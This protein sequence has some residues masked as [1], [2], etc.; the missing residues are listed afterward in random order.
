MATVNIIRYKHK[1]NSNGTSPII[2]QIIHQRKIKRISLG[3]RYDCTSD[4]WN[5]AAKEYNRNFPE[6]KAKNVILQKFKT[7]AN[8]IIENF[9]KVG[10]PFSFKAFETIFRGS[11]KNVSTLFE[12]FEERINEMKAQ[13]QLSNASIYKATKSILNQFESNKNLAFTDI[14]YQ[15]L[16][17]FEIY[18]KERGSNGGGINNHMRT[19]RALINE[20]MKRGFLSLEQ[21]PFKSAWNGNGYSFSHI[22]SD[23]K[24]RAVSPED[25][26]KLKNFPIQ[27]F[28]DLNFAY[29]IFMFSYYS[30]GMNINDIFKL[31]KS[32]VYNNRLSFNRTK[33]GKQMSVNLTEPLKTILKEFEN[34]KNDFLFPVLNESHHTPEDVKKQIANTLKQINYRLKKIAEILEIDVDLTSYVARHNYATTLKRNGGDVSKI[35]EALG[36]SDINTTKAYLKKFEDSEIDELDKLL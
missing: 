11:G 12:F 1:V 2:L 4:Q 27:N 10:K 19:F 16:T 13:N 9:A 23:A 18:L 8:D 35:S 26:E 21:Y 7:S 28:P 32:N 30:R 15:F 17:R 6:Y 5:E 33:T 34:T 36:H 22:K 31:K 25:L 20:A 29:K 24:P 3:S 14:D